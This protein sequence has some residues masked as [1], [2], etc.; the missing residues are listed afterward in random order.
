MWSL[1]NRERKRETFGDSSPWLTRV[2]G[3]RNKLIS[4]M[5][6]LE[7]LGNHLKI[8]PYLRINR[9][10]ESQASVVDL[11]HSLFPCISRPEGSL[12]TGV[13]DGCEPPSS[14]PLLG[15]AHGLPLH[16]SA[17]VSGAVQ[18]SCQTPSPPSS[19]F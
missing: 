18:S 8:Y 2:S 9:K 19:G 14:T 17:C 10:S 1:K 3:K 4:S 15:E 11:S 6:C 16:I 5:S 7:S 12:R 13:R